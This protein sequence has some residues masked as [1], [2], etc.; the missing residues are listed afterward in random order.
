[1]LFL[2]YLIHEYE[3]FLTF[4]LQSLKF[5]VVEVKYIEHIINIILENNDFK[6][7]RTREIYYQIQDLDGLVVV[8]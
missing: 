4:K 5:Q 3:Y 1:M 6:L 8:G 2:S 7:L